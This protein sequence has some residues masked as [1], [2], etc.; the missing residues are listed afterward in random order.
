MAVANRLAREADVVVEVDTSALGLG[1][2]SP[3]A[4]DVRTGKRLAIVGG[5]VTVHV[6]GRSYTYISLTP[7]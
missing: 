3:M 2:G 4:T 5:R 1:G 7:R 6:E